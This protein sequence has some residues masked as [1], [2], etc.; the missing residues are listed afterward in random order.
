MSYKQAII[1]LT[2][3]QK[4]LFLQA[5]TSNSRLKI[6][7]GPKQLN[8][9][10]DTLLVTQS[11]LKSLINAKTSN[12][13]VTLTF[14]NKQLQAM[15]EQVGNGILDSIGSFFKGAASTVST[16]ASRAANKVGK[17]W[18][19]E[20]AKPKP[21]ELTTFNKT[22]TRRHKQSA[23]TEDIEARQNLIKREMRA[24]TVPLRDQLIFDKMRKD[25]EKWLS[26]LPPRP[27]RETEEAMRQRIER[28]DKLMKPIKYNTTEEAMHDRW[29][30]RNV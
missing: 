1:D 16:A 7:L 4:K 14:T 11:Q 8:G 25:R 6:R 24:S 26:T 3:T 20:Y 9:K 15:G 10:G 12:K 17:W 29:W 21:T 5:L 30:E 2:D 19:G 23:R 13:P 28:H 22:Q 18:K 27:Q